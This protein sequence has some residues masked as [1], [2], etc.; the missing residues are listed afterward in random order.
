MTDTIALLNDIR[1]LQTKLEMRHRNADSRKS[2]DELTTLLNELKQIE[3]ARNANADAPADD[4]KEIK[5]LLERLNHLR[6]I[7]GKKSLNQWNG[8]LKDLSTAISDTKRTHQAM[9]DAENK[10]M[11]A[12][13]KA[14]VEKKPTTTKAKVEAKTKKTPAAPINAAGEKTSI[15]AKVAAKLG[16]SPKVARNK[17][18]RAH[19]SDWKK[20]T[21]KQ[22]EAT[23]RG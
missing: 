17:L 23:L 8:S 19:G 20:L 13:V 22:I 12:K 2:A 18:R 15:A 5:R 3:A 9:M 16:M 10:E 4:P 1:A 21:E 6:G 11:K 14:A 7:I